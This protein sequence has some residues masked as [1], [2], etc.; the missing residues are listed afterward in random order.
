ML[1]AELSKQDFWGTHT[2]L[3]THTLS[4]G[5][6]QQQFKHRSNQHY[7]SPNFLEA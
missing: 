4:V 3:H 2:P 1:N 7:K 5:K 6:R